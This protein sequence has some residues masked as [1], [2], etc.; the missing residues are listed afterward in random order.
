MLYERERQIVTTS[1]L[2]H[3]DEF[4]IGADRTEQSHEAMHLLGA[5]SFEGV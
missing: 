5:V 4:A 1:L 3:V 2:Q